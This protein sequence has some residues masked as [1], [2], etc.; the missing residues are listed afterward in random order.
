VAHKP[1]ASS[2][3]DPEPFYAWPGLPLEENHVNLRLFHSEE[4]ARRAS[5][6]GIGRL[7][8]LALQKDLGWLQRD[9]RALV[10]LEPLFRG[11]CLA[12]ELQAAAFENLKR[13]LLPAEPFTP[14]TEV[15]FRAA[16]ESVRAHL[17]GLA[18]QL[19]DR[20]EPI[21]KLRQEVARRCPPPAP[22][23][24]RAP[25]L[26][27]LSQ[28]T[29][30][31]APV[32]APNPLAG[33]LDSLLPRNF[34]AVIPFERLPHL[35]RYLKA[36]LIRAERAALNPVKDQERARLLAPYHEALRKLQA[37]PHASIATRREIEE[38]RWMVEEYKVSL[39]A[40]ELGTAMPVS[41]KRLDQHIEK[42]RG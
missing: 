32:R 30:A 26:T 4:T 28:L 37:D 18:T 7:I 33:E 34:L 2:Q 25:R 10:R 38:F 42:I 11:L 16:V 14:L 23:P 19:M 29:T 31:P 21:L 1:P 15:N 8:E 12:D 9:L 41:P 24:A 6:G 40:Q 20:V 5:V 22:A 36:M 13:H 27:S 17:P 39:F 3:K 35:P